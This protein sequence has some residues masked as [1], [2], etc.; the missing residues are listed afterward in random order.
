[1]KKVLVSFLAFLCFSFLNTA[2]SQ[3]MYSKEYVIQKSTNFSEFLNLDESTK[4]KV[5]YY[6]FDNNEKLKLLQNEVADMLPAEFTE[7]QKSLRIE[8]ETNLFTLLTAEQ[9]LLFPS[10]ADQSSFF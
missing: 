10:F 9:I 5:F 7:R 3:E 4:Q 2:F 8:L 1:M 6:V